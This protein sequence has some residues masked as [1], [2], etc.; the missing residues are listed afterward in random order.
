VITR[1][2]PPSTVILLQLSK[3]RAIRK[4][5]D[6]PHMS[7]LL[8]KKDKDISFGKTLSSQSHQKAN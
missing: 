6:I 1:H 4:A 2:F 5:K 8:E 3:S 7:R